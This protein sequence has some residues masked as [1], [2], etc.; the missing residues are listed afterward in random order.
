MSSLTPALQPETRAAKIVASLV[1]LSAFTLGFLILNL[2]AGSAQ[3]QRRFSLDLR[4]AD[5]ADQGAIPRGFTCDGAGIS[6][7][8]EWSAAPA[9]TRS[10]AIVM[11]DPDAPFDFTH[12]LVYN[13]PAEARG[14]SENASG[15]RALP[16]GSME[17]ANSYGSSGYAGPCPPARE[18][19]H[20]YFRLY[21]LDIRLNL[22]QGATREQVD[23]ATAH[24]IVAQGQTIGVYRRSSH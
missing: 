18:L 4:S 10:F 14:L 17:G 5:F 24:H 1:I 22:P 7:G 8:L 6:P 21:A 9:G 2:R 3:S 11:D 16:Q 13:L 23:S 20:Y 12:W 15:H 19:H